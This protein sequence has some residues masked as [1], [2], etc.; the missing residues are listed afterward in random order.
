MGG[1]VRVPVGGRSKDTKSESGRRQVGDQ[2]VSRY[3]LLV[4][5]RVKALRATSTI[6]F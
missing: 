3:K 6:A 2:N 1:D 5:G 4:L